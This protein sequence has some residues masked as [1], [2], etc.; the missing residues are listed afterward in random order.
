M[1]AVEIIKKIIPLLEK[2]DKWQVHKE[3]RNFKALM[4]EKQK[5]LEEFLRKTK[6]RG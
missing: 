1:V 2:K 4:D 3:Q 5:K 6:K